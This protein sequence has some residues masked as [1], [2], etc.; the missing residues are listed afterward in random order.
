M[1]FTNSA[2]TYSAGAGQVLA[3][4]GQRG[5]LDL[6]PHGHGEAEHTFNSAG[7]LISLTDRNG[8]SHVS[9]PR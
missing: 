5:Q 9:R 1:T 3:H 2:G 4:A 7:Q 8:Y 6:R